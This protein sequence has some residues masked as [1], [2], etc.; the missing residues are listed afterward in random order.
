MSRM[1]SLK[2]KQVIYIAKSQDLYIQFEDAIVTGYDTACFVEVPYGTARRF[3]DSADRDKFF[4]DFIRTKYKFYATFIEVA[5][6]NV[7]ITPA[8]H[9]P[10][11]R[12][13]Y[14]HIFH[15]FVESISI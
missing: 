5:E 15:S 4:Q 12:T 14:P 7:P 11:V 10:D 1:N 8:K 2:I 13:E 6:M 3:K 9:I